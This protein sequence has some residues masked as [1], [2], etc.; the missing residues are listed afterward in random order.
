MKKCFPEERT[1]QYPETIFGSISF[2]WWLSTCM[3]DQA[4][5]GREHA[6]GRCVGKGE[7]TSI[8]DLK[9]IKIF[10]ALNIIQIIQDHQ[11]H[12]TSCFPRSMSVSVRA[13][14][15]PF[16]FRYCN[17]VCRLSVMKIGEEVKICKECV[18]SSALTKILWQ[19][20]TLPLYFW[21][22]VGGGVGA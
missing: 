5:I 6:W 21:E 4:S 16:L 2:F 7:T 10:E 9:V 11:N 13:V 14:G 1:R 17:E 3:C 15:S 22:W 20:L 8:F 19:S 18:A 12:K